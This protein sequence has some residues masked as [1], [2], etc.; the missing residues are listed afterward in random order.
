MVPV[1]FRYAP[2]K[3]NINITFWCIMIS[4]EIPFKNHGWGSQKNLQQIRKYF[5][6]M[7]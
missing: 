1:Q 4:R 2:N 6:F 5:R 7:K 3:Y